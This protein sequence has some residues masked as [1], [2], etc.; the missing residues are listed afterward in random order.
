MD[1]KIVEIRGGACSYPL[2]LSQDSY[3]AKARMDR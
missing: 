2:F 3:T 1:R